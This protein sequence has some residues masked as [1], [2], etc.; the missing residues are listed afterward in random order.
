[1]LAIPCHFMYRHGFFMGMGTVH[2]RLKRH[3]AA[4]EQ[5]QDQGKSQS[6]MGSAQHE[7]GPT[8]G[9]KRKVTPIRAR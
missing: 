6:L 1:M 7:A 5:Q 2:S 8:T 9:D 3:T 4:G